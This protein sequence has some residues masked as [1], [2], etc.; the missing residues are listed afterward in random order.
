VLPWKNP[1]DSKQITVSASST[2]GEYKNP[3]V[4]VNHDGHGDFS[5]GLDESRNP[6]QWVRIDLGIHKPIAP[7]YYCMKGTTIGH[8]MKSWN[9]EG[10][11]DDIN[12][13][14]ISEHKDVDLKWEGSREAVSFP[15]KCDK[16]Y[17]YFR[18]KT[19]GKGF[20]TDYA[21]VRKLFNRYIYH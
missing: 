12:W 16:K 4:C 3:N 18:I 11:N 1:A 9:L 10:S 14:V 17:R 7:N 13:S 20:Y 15:V 2:Y 6:G 5:T 19:T 8:S 21:F